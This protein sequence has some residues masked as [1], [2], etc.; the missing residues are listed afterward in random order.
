[1]RSGVAKRLVWNGQW[2]PVLFE[3][4]QLLDMNNMVVQRFLHGCL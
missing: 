1:M 4:M 2:L 3:T